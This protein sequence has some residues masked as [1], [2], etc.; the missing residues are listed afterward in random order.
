MRPTLVF[1]HHSNF[2]DRVFRH[3]EELPPN[4]FKQDVIDRLLDS[5]RL[6][7]HRERRSLYRLLHVFS[8]CKE[9]EPLTEEE[10][11]SYSL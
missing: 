10:I 9:R 8:G 7:E 11:E 2:G 5:G 3:G 1:V 6:H 4:F